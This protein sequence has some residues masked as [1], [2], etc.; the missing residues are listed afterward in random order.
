MNTKSDSLFKLIKS[1]TKGEKG[2]FLKHGGKDQGDDLKYLKLFNKID[3]QNEYDEMQIIKEFK[4]ETFVKQLHVTKN[5]L[6][7]KILRNLFLFNSVKSPGFKI[8]ENINS[9]NILYE[10]GLYKEA[11]T[12]LLKTKILAYEYGIYGEILELI[13]LHKKL[14]LKFMKEDILITLNKFSMEEKETISMIKNIS[15][16]RKL[17]E[18]IY[19]MIKNEGSIRNSKQRNRYLKIIKNSLIKDENRALTYESRILYCLIQFIYS[20]AEGDD[21]LTLQSSIKLISQIEKTPHRVTEFTREHILAMGGYLSS[22]FNLG[23]Y[24]ESMNIIK[25][26]RDC[27]VSILELKQYIFFTTYLI[28][29]LINIHSCRFEKGKSLISAIEKGL[30]KYGLKNPESN[31]VILYEKIFFLYFA[32]G[33]YANALKW[34]NRILNLNQKI[35]IDIY[36]NTLICNLLIHYELN[37]TNLLRYALINTY[38][39]F[40]RNKRL[41][42]FEEVVLKYIRKLSAGNDLQYEFGLLKK[43]LQELEKDPYERVPLE[44]FDYIC[45]LD[46]KI[47]NKTFAEIKKDKL[48]RKNLHKLKLES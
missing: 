12:I 45:W 6:Y 10:K 28:E 27:R 30:K 5:Y 9:V 39:F 16:Y 23:N 20:Q 32:L 47:E 11:L 14:I 34:N 48:N 26:M 19:V 2:Y 44:Y 18:N 37:N 42:K 46:S 22:S 40:Y 4:D 7:N 29:L 43:E 35:R 17:F 31:E 15:E 13:K 25:T 21:D 1:L 33:D 38:R 24:E 3:L 41:Y 8:A 36:T